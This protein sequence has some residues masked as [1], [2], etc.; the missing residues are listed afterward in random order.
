[1]EKKWEKAIEL[2]KLGYLPK[3]VSIKSDLKL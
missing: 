1:M 3:Y 2:L